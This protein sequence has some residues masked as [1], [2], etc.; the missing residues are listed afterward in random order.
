MDERERERDLVQIDEAAF[1]G[2]AIMEIF[3]FSGVCE[4]HNRIS[5]IETTSYQW[6]QTLHFFSSL[7][8]IFNAN[9]FVFFVWTLP[10][11]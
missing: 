11:T 6:L 10:L 5:D 1:G 8:L 7:L 9:L 3:R 4:S 2:E